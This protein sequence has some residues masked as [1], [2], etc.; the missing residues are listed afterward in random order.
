MSDLE[1]NEI[2]D[3]GEERIRGESEGNSD[4]EAQI[5]RTRTTK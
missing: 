2:G 3:D 5:I 1:I 4:G